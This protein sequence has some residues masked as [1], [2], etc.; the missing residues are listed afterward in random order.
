MNVKNITII[1]GTTKYLNIDVLNVNGNRMDLTGFKAF[2]SIK[3]N[4]IIITRRECEIKNNIVYVEFE[5]KDTL[6]KYNSSLQYEVRIVDD[7][8]NTVLA[9][10]KGE[11]KV[12]K[13]I[14]PI[15]SETVKIIDINKK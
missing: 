5:P 11:I 14:D 9:I 12:I 13:S 7:E 2:M 15:I 6:G 4:D 3:C 1:E 10:K 8:T